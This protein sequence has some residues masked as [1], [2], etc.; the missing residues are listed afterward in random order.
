MAQIKLAEYTF[1]NS[2]ADI[3]PELTPS[4]ITMTKDDV[5][6][7]TTT[8]RIVY[9]DDATMPTQISFNFCSN[10]LTVDFL[11]VNN[12]INSARGMFNRCSSLTYINTSN[13]ITSNITD[14][15]SMFD[16]CTSLE[17][18]DLTSFDTTNVTVASY[19]FNRWS[20]SQKV[21][22]SSKWTLG[23]NFP[24]TFIIAFANIIAIYKFDQNTYENLIPEFN[25]DFIDYAYND[26]IDTDGYT[27]RT[28]G[29]GSGNLP[30]L[31]RFG[32]ETQTDREKSLLE[33][34]RCD[35]ENVTDMSYM[36]R[37]C[38]LL[39]SLDVSNFNTSKVT[40]M[41]NMFRNC[42]S[43][44][45]LNIS[46]FDT[47]K[48]TDMYAMFQ[49]CSSLTSLDVSKFDTNKVNNMTQMFYGC[50]KLT[51]LDVSNFD[52]KQVTNMSNMFRDCSLLTSLDVSNF[53]TSQVIDMQ[54]MFDNCSSLTSL[55]VSNFN[56][57]QVTSMYSMFRSCSSLTSLDVSNFNT[58]KVT[59][60][61]NMFRFCTSLTSLDISNFNTSQVTITTYMLDSTKNLKDVGTIY[62]DSLTINKI[63]DLITTDT[64]I[65][66]SDAKLE[67]L[68][69]KENI[70]YKEY[71]MNILESD[72][73]I[74]LCGIGDIYDELNL[75]TGELTQRIGNITLKGEEGWEQSQPDVN[76]NVICDRFKL[77]K[78][79]MKY[80]TQ[81]IISNIPIYTN[82]HNAYNINEVC[83]D[84]HGLSD[85]YLYIPRNL[86]EGAVGEVPNINK[87]KIYLQ[88]NPIT[89]QYELAIPII[90]ITNLKNKP[91]INWEGDTYLYLENNTLYPQLDCEIESINY[92]EIPKLKANTLYTLRSV[93][94]PTQ[95]IFGGLTYRTKNNMILTSGSSDNLLY[96]D[97]EVRKVVLI[98]GDVR[99]RNFDYFE[100]IESLGAVEI[101]THKTNMPIFAK[102]GR[103]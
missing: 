93:G 40:N 5:V 73:E 56:T 24:P 68:T 62:C 11:N 38:S 21:Y 86:Y 1:D 23:T 87:L 92:Y 12:N 54:V 63:S 22:V 8:R 98:E 2:V 39:T 88:N 96:F 51:L 3:M 18:L 6:N 72:E 42:S 46:N 28:I 85:F 25:I 82:G 33:V 7:S 60:I 99:D 65:W 69:K 29:N 9:I 94:E 36:F 89:V 52:T 20:S 45:L 95:C 13:W 32:A 48:V 27:I 84:T 90:K 100:G 61:G 77:P 37:E 34:Y 91:S 67:D 101:V 83:I 26:V 76:A 66:Y 44:T 16:M 79:D 102:G 50:S 49:H 19:M 59:D 47:S 74:N 64:T 30:T 55:D 15:V 31:M 103:K 57:S 70:T 80:Q 41:N 35:T 75:E 4:T 97:K 78:K 58:E 43:L 17:S 14:M 53:D 71:K 10:L 81:K